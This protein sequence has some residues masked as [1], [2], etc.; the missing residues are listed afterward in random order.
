MEKKEILR[1]RGIYLKDLREA[2]NLSQRDLAKKA[3]IHSQS[4]QQYEQGISDLCNVCY[5]KFCRYAD[6]LNLYPQAL[7]DNL[8]GVGKNE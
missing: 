8:K 1:I 5:E 2:Q 7:H 4:I 3:D 6:A